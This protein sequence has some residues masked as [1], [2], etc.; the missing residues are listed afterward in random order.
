M[1]LVS[2]ADI[3]QPKPPDVCSPVIN[4]VSVMWDSALFGDEVRA[5]EN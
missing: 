5:K 4:V 2:V 1:F 3:S